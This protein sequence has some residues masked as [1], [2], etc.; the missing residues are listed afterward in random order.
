MNKYIFSLSV[1]FF[2][3]L[4]YA[5]FSFNYNFNFFNINI[6][7]ISLLIE[8]IIIFFIIYIILVLIVKS[9]TKVKDFGL[10]IPKADLTIKNF[11]KDNLDNFSLKQKNKIYKENKNFQEIDKDF[12]K[13]VLKKL[14]FFD[15]KNEKIDPPLFSDFPEDN[16]EMPKE[17]DFINKK[18]SIIKENI[19]EPVVIENNITEKKEFKENKLSFKKLDKFNDF[20]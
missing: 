7:Y 5:F 10:N 18:T 14:E 9:S 1:S 12:Q 17:E 20:L 6:N 11:N 3:S 15:I 4:I 16:I 8:F 2:L 13:K 19:E